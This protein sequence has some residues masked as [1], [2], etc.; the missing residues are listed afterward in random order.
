[1]IETKKIKTLIPI[2][3]V[4]L[5]LPLLFRSLGDFPRRTVLKE[6]L[7]LATLL[8][9]SL[10]LGLF[11]LTRA[12]RHSVTNLTMRT[13]VT[14]HKIVGYLVVVVLLLHPVFIVLPRH[15]ESGITPK[16]AFVTMITT[17]HSRGIVLGMIAW[18]L[19]LILGLTCLL[20][21]RLPM[22]FKT[23]RLCHGLLAVLFVVPATW[24]AL[25]LGRHMNRPMSIYMI[26]VATGGV[27]LLLKI[28][29]VKPSKDKKEAL[30]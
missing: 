21:N 28:L 26:I 23:W 25:D 27:M 9:F 3:L 6:S 19:M 14:L 11:Y 4:L 16:E 10:M 20:R 5:G 12:G 30:S 1:M 24:H 15:F 17:T 2:A 13:T 7:S 8:A 29:I 18:C 22:T